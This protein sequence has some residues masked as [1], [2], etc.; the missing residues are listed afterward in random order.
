MGQS[1]KLIKTQI[2]RDEPFAAVSRHAYPSQFWTAFALAH[3]NTINM[4]RCVSQPTMYI[5]LRWQ[6]LGQKCVVSSSGVCTSRVY[7]SEST[8]R[9]LSHSAFNF[10]LRSSAPASALALLS[11]ASCLSSA[12]YLPS[13]NQ[14]QQDER[15]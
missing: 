4:V 12:P 3:R 5:V 10:I 13:G 15:W 14:T 9:L 2:K 1:I 8:D 11:L 6:I 7:T